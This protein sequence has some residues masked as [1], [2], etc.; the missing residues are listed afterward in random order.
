MEAESLWGGINMMLILNLETIKPTKTAL[1][2]PGIIANFMK[3]G[4]EGVS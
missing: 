3:K 4:V 2:D 1:Q